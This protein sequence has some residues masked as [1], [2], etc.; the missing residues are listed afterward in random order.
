MSPATLYPVESSEVIHSSY[1]PEAEEVILGDFNV[2]N[3]LRAYSTN[4]AG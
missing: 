3:N 4:T 1:V 2:N